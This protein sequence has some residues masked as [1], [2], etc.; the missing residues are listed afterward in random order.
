MKFYGHGI[1]WDKDK[2]KAL[3]KFINGE[4]E[5][6]DSIIIDKLKELNF[7]FD[8][9]D[10]NETIKSENKNDIDYEALEY[11]DLKKIAKDCGINTYKM[12]QGE[13]ISALKKVGE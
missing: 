13:I 1:V 7:V 6:D 10:T 8:G 9:I 3:C 5:T 2:N 11:K 4:Y 12:K